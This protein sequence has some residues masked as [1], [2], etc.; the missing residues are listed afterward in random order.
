MNF[1]ARPWVYNTL[2]IGPDFKTPERRP[3]LRPGV[4]SSWPIR[5]TSVAGGAPEV[6]RDARARDGC[7]DPREYARVAIGSGL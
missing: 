4:S 5:T 2:S 1:D 3:Y 6:D 7:G